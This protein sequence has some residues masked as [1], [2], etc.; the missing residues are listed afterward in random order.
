MFI[1]SDDDGDSRLYGIWTNLKVKASLSSVVMLRLH[2][3]FFFRFSAGN[4]AVKFPNIEISKRKIYFKCLL[5]FRRPE[6]E[7]LLPLLLLKTHYESSSFVFQFPSSERR[8]S[9]HVINTFSSQLSILTTV[10]N[11]SIW[12]L[13]WMVAAEF[14]RGSIKLLD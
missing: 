4:N 2:G 6:C 12:R 7:I 1:C 11:G 14:K 9:P 13:S 5:F 3:F 8:Q 10:K